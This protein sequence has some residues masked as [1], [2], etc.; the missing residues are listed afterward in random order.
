MPLSYAHVSCYIVVKVGSTQPV[1]HHMFSPEGHLSVWYS[2]S[3][4]H[5]LYFLLI[6]DIFRFPDN[7]NIPVFYYRPY[8]GFVQINKGSFIK[9]LKCFTNY[10]YNMIGFL[11]YSGGMV[12][13][14]HRFV[15]LDL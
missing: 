6:K 13:E 7:V 9:M 15:L 12:M 8:I 3:S 5:F 4:L 1:G 14:F 2:S 11:S 10:G